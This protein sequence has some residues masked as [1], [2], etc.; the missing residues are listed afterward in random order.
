MRRSAQAHDPLADYKVHEIK[1]LSG[2][3]D[4]PRARQLL[5]SVAR[6]VQPIMRRR[7]WRVPL[8]SE[9]FPR[10]PNLLGININRGQEIRI[11]LRPHHRP[12]DFY[13]DSHIIMTMLHE[14]TH[15]VHG[16]HLAPFYK[17]LDELK[18][19]AEELMAKGVSGTGQ[20]F[21]AAS[22][23]RLGQYSFIPT[24]NPPEYKKRDAVLKVGSRGIS[25]AGKLTS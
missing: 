16:P 18:A 21:D 3:E 13:D 25:T 14:L 1:V 4:V 7:Q 6:Q 9:F 5:E 11:R 15:I 22:V 20:G 23:G 8:L 19:E 12:A 17:L 10:N 24:H 2:K